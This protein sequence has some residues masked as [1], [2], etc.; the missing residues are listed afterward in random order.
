MKILE[1]HL[2]GVLVIELPIYRDNRG[3]FV[4]TW[5]QNRY[6]A[7]GLNFAFVQDNLSFSRKGVLR[8]LHYQHPAGQGKLVSVVQGAVFDVTVD[9]RTR[10]AHLRPK[11]RRRAIR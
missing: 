3:H 8:G 2:P 5:N 10:I 6:A 11:L 7:T 1:T 9:I 4:E